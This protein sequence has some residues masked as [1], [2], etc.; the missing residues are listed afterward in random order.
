MMRFVRALRSLALAA[1]CGCAALFLL[2]ALTEG[3]AERRL[4]RSLSA[5]PD[6]DFT[7]DIASLQSQ[8]RITEALD[9]ARYVTNNT[10][11]P[12]QTTASNL[13]A[14][15]E[16]EQ[17]SVWH[18]ADRMAKGF[19]KGTGLSVE[20]MGGAIASDMVVYG[21]CRDLLIQGYYRVTGRETD[22]VVAA[23]ASVGLLTELVDALDWAPAVLKAFRKAN[24]MS[25]RFGDWLVEV[26]RRSTKARQIDPAL[27]QVFENLK[28]L[29][30]RLG[31][32]KTAAVFK[33]AD[34]ADDLAALAKCADAHPDDVYRFLETAGGEGLPL[35][36]RVADEPRGFERLA[37]ATRKGLPGISALRKGGELRHVTLFVRYGER[38]LRSLRLQRPQQFLHAL[39]M[40]SPAARTAL[41]GAAGLLLAIALWLF[42]STF[43][44]GSSASGYS[45]HR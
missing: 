9:W 11:L 44:R 37:L 18:Q 4:L 40:R 5:L 21:D 26:C 27:Q 19:I 33:H 6:H 16:G 41:W 45:L 3:L 30:D 2:S 14:Q 24:V 15:L 22:A 8:G 43:C 1:A 20:E 23:L 25:R 32:A 35:L 34:N 29:H 13:V 10:A 39:A 28:R 38:V 31:L 12:G 17:T 36:L 42:L 7:S